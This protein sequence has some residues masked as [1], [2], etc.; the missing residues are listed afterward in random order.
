MAT[1]FGDEL[2]RL[3]NERGI[4]QQDMADQVAKLGVTFSRS[5]LGMLEQGN[6]ERLGADVL[7][8]ICEVLG[9]KCTHFQVFLA[10]PVSAQSEES[11]TVT[12]T[13]KRKPGRPK[14]SV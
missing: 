11:A 7:F 13:P 5:F 1:S 14:K 3:R 2:K 8:R 6:A 12:P 10:P 4:S 9:V